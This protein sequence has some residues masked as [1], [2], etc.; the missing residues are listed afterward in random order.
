MPAGSDINERDLS[1]E[2]GVSR[3]PLREA[4]LSLEK[5]GI[6]EARPRHG[7]AVTALTA[8]DAEEIY[9]MIAALEALALESSDFHELLTELDT[10][11]AINTEMG[12]AV[13]DAYRA[14][15]LDDEFHKHLLG[16]CRNGRLLETIAAL[17]RI[18]HRYEYAYMREM[19]SVP[20]SVREHE[21]ILR[22]L[23]AGDVAQ[24]TAT[25]RQNWL[26]AKDLLVA[27]LDG[28]R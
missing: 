19:A 14:Q 3:T 9:P 25:V 24:A 6:V 17:K 1:T 18:I 7:W 15:M 5:E 16:T 11:T 20:I 28:A 27:W 21:E 10:L 22:A 4:L 8:A 2:L 26:R 23:R 13:D 12:E